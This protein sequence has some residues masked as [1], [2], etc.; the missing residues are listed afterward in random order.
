MNY[1][2]QTS[3]NA[4]LRMHIKR[5]L[6][7][8]AL[9]YYQSEDIQELLRQRPWRVSRRESTMRVTSTSGG[10]TC[11]ALG[12]PQPGRGGAAA[13]AR[14]IAPPAGNGRALCLVTHYLHKTLT[15]KSLT[16]AQR[17][18]CVHSKHTF[19]H[20]HATSIFF[21]LLTLNSALMFYL[22]YCMTENA[23]SKMQKF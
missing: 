1:T 8:W 9:L 12:T 10:V 5:S 13:T 14:S 4:S 18:K 20:K 7:G 17:S 2:N 19:M 21:L 22:K 3:S 23:K 11:C 15:W 6:I 16:P